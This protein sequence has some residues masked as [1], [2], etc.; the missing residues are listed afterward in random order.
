MNE[1]DKLI[2]GKLLKIASNQQKILTHL[3]QAQQ[4]PNIQYLK[5][6]AMVTAA[7]S[8][9]SATDV[10]VTANATNSPAPTSNITISGGYTVKVS[11][12]PK[13]NEVREKFIRQLRAFVAAQKPNDQELANLSVIFVG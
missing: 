2:L 12:A 11:G 6:A 8:G 3:A 7:N 13:Q 1:K 5:Q 10:Q 9:F 4:D